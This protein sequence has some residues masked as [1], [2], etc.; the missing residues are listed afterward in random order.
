MRINRLASVINRGTFYM[1]PRFAMG[2]LPMVARFLSGE[3]V[4][5]FDDDE[6]EEKRELAAYAIRPDGAMITYTGA[7]SSNTLFR[8]VPRGSI[9]VIKVEGVILKDDYCGAPGTQ[10]MD[11]WVREARDND[12]IIG[13]IIHVNSGGGSVEGTGEFA[14]TIKETTAIKPVIG[15][16]DGLVASAGYWIFSSCT[17]CYVSFATVEIGS[18]GTAINMYDNREMLKM[19]GYK[20]VYVNAD[21]SV[22]KNMAPQRAMDGEYG[23]LKTYILNPTNDIFLAAVKVNRPDLVLTESEGKDQFGKTVT[24]IEPLSGHVYIAGAAIENGLIDGIRSFEGVCDRVLELSEN[25]TANSQK[26]NNMFGNKFSKLSALAGVAAASITAEQVEE[27]NKQ[28]SAQNIEGVTLCLDS[29]LEK[30]AK[31][32]N[33]T[34]AADLV[35]ANSTI[36]EL[37]TQLK[38]EQDKVTTLTE[39]KSTLTTSNETLQAKVEELGGEAADQRTTG[40]KVGSDNIPETDNGSEDEVISEADAQLKKMKAQINGLPKR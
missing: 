13:I 17:E 16:C 18:I 21:A 40:K 2:Y 31:S 20:R 1:D 10:T 37:R 30:Y 39:E 34:A 26:S 11:R 24:R 3:T 15:W 4:S 5:F 9:A 38:A 29:E 35:K 36:E 33:S 27:V 22:D 23:D 25:P 14:T 8:D 6:D 12:N 7:D 19:M 28:I 32:E